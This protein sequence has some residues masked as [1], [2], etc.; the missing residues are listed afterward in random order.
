MNRFNIELADPSTNYF[1]IDTKG[2]GAHGDVDFEKYQ[3]SKNR[4]NL[5]KQGDLFIYRRPSKA[6][7]T[8][9][10][11][12]FG[13]GKFG[14]IAG[15][16]RL[17]SIVEKP[18]PFNPYIHPDVLDNFPWKWKTRGKTWEHFFN[19]YGMNNITKQ[20]FINLLDLG[21]DTDTDYVYDSQAASEAVQNIQKKNYYASDNETTSKARSKQAAFSNEVKTNYNDRCAICNISNR[22]FLIGSHIIPWSER[23]DIRLDPANGLCLCSLHDKAFDKGYITLND[24]YSIYISPHVDN[25]PVLNELLSPYSSLKIRLPK[26]DKPKKEYLKYHRD[27]IFKK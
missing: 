10:F 24:D 3:W 21:I 17:T 1:I 15:N 22:D 2:G 7:A 25:D 16:N 27:N 6:S 23:K 26:Q 12:F 14:T 20:D 4:Y 11:Y 13:A 18:Y 5:V 8:G 19:Q 9:K